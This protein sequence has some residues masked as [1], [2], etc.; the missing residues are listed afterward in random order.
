[1]GACFL[2]KPL[3]SAATANSASGI[4]RIHALLVTAT[5]VGSWTEHCC[6]TTRQGFLGA[7]F[8]PEWHFP[9]PSEPG[10]LQEEAASSV[11]LRGGV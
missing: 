10:M 3:P 4:G 6:S 5:D 7:E 2:A 9:F 1:M 8:P 11:R